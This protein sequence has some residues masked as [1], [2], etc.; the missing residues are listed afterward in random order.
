M[1]KA[2]LILA[3]AAT[4]L[5]AA[6]SAISAKAKTTPAEQLDKLLAG[7]VAGKP[8]SCITLSDSR[9]MQVIDGTAIV[10]GWGRTIW[11][12]RTTDPASLDSDD[13]LVSKV[14]GS[15]VCKLDIMQQHDRSGG[16]NRGFVSLVEF[17]PYRKVG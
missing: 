13:V 10:Y 14:W 9:D 1:N 5:A 16:F 4:A 3:A 12:N 17:V 2:L 8:V 11:V 15:S 7:R 6:P